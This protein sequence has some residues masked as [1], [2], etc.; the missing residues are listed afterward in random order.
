MA[1]GFKR[2]PS[3]SLDGMPTGDQSVQLD[4]VIANFEFV[5]Q[6]GVTQH[7]GNFRQDFKVLLG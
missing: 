2:Q 7:L 6:C 4:G 1:V 5:A 3:N